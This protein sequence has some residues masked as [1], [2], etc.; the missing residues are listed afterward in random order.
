MFQ[1]CPL[2]IYVGDR[3]IKPEKVHEMLKGALVEVSFELRH[4]CIQKKHED[5]FNALVQQVLILQPGKARPCN[6]FKRRNVFDG[7]VRPCPVLCNAN[8]ENG[9]AENS[10]DV[11]DKTVGSSRIALRP[12]AE[13]SQEASSLTHRVFMPMP[14]GV[15]NTP[16]SIANGTAPPA[17]G[18]SS[19][20]KCFFLLLLAS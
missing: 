11:T 14:T 8:K 2:P 19:S 10:D 12:F 16:Q 7:P 3:F 20:C 17:A 1:A 18:P 15:S 5:S 13:C 9:T 6:A 4:Y